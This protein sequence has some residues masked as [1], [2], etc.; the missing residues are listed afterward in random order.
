MSKDVLN[1][2]VFSLRLANAHDDFGEIVFGSSKPPPGTEEP[3]VLPLLDD[4]RH[5]DVADV[6]PIS[7]DGFQFDAPNGSKHGP[8]FSNVTA[9]ILTTFPGIAL[10]AGWASII[11]NLIGAVQGPGEYGPYRLVPCEK[12]GTLPPLTFNLGGETEP[13]VVSSE[14]WIQEIH[15]DWV[16]KPFCSSMLVDSGHFFTDPQLATLGSAFLSG[17]HTTFGLDEHF[18]SCKSK[19][20]IF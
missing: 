6:W 12:R 5:P 10:P 20:R 19:L 13:L 9:V 8:E 17:F 2:P 1:E 18:V 7:F 11:N 4:D 15:L 14:E 3:V 16:A